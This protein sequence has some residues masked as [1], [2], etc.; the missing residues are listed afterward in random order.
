MDYFLL[1]Q[2]AM[3]SKN[4]IATP[5][6]VAAS[7]AMAARF[8]SGFQTSSAI[9]EQHAG[10]EGHHR[11]QIPDAVLSVSTLDDVVDAVAICRTHQIPIIPYGA[12]TSLEGH[13]S[14]VQGGISLDMSKLDHII[15]IDADNLR[16][17]VGAGVTREQ[18]NLALRDKG[19]FF[20]IDPGA[21]ATLGGMASTRASGTNA[22]RYG[23]MRDNTLSLQVVLADGNVIETGTKA[24]KTA[25][26]YDLTALFVGSEGTLGIVTELTLKLSG[27][28]E[29]II[30]GTCHFDDLHG[31]V[32]T[33]ITAIQIGIPL[34][35]I[36]LLDDAQIIACNSYSGLGLP[37]KP[38]LFLEFHGSEHAV[39]E[40]SAIFA[41]IAQ[42]NGGSALEIASQAEDRT[43]LWKARHNAYFA[44]KSLRP[45]ALIWSTDVCVPIA[46]LAESVLEAREEIEQ[47]GLLATIVGHVGDGNFHVLFVL[48]PECPE[49]RHKAS[50][51]NAHMVERALAV[52][53]TCT[54]EHGIGIGVSGKNPPRG[55]GSG[56]VI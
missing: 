34:A 4:P 33:V 52:G 25:A 13:L 21:N 3:K 48:N 43:R 28:A 17:R 8:G 12:G 16:C 35:R 41:E 5:D 42:A 46:S 53:G 36:E 54:G 2:M 51:V 9:C 26:G 19:L 39:S 1:E 15:E 27:I 38:T 24:A 40:Q 6:F 20:P 32:R 18:L 14:A 11:H 29:T 37:A 56:A 44:A 55:L 47:Q 30:A 31:A 10:L 7:N 45:N 50:I 23:T 22:I 49:D